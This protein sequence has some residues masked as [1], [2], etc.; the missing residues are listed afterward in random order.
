MR[1]TD[2]GIRLTMRYLIRSRFRRGSENAIW[3]D[4]LEEFGRE[5][6]LR[7]SHHSGRTEIERKA[8][9]ASPAPSHEVMGRG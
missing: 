3:Q 5:P 6:D 8:F 2:Q 9:P 4:V 7:L 1:G